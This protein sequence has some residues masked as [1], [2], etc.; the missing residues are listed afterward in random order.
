MGVHQRT[1]F[2]ERYRRLKKEGK[3]VKCARQ[4]ALKQHVLCLD[5]NTFH[6]FKSKMR[7]S[8]DPQ[9]CIARTQD[10]IKKHPKEHK[11]MHSDWMK[12]NPNYHKEY[13]Q[14][15]KRWNNIKSIAKE[16]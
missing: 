6:L 11:K 3:C 1:Y 2:K 7:Y 12:K 15:R 13:Y 9:K 14:R 5:C 10:W 8:L 4:K 16:S